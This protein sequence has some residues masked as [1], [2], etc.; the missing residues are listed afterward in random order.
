MTATQ[1]MTVAAAVVALTQLLK[2]M[3]VD[4]KHGPILVL[5]IALLG[6]TL[7]AWS[8][9]PNGLDKSHAWDMFAA[10]ITVATAAAGVFGFTRAVADKVVQT[11]TLSSDIP[12]A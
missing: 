6:V 8:Q 9:I 5:I 1:I 10:W 11:K 3:G 4:N 7:Y 12:S 2:W